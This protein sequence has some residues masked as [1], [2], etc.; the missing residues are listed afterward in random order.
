MLCTF[1]TLQ[2][3]LLQEAFSSVIGA[4]AGRLNAAKLAPL[5]VGLELLYKCIWYIECTFLAGLAILGHGVELGGE[6]VNLAELLGVGEHSKHTVFEVVGDAELFH[7]STAL[8]GSVFQFA[9]GVCEDEFLQVL[10]TI[11]C[12]NANPIGM[13]AQNNAL[14]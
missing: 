3:G 8:K 2:V 7:S 10:A 9:H 12:A 5:L 6:Q 11:E 14:Q 1:L 4:L 13:L